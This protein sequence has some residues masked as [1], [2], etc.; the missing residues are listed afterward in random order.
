VVGAEVPGERPCSNTPSLARIRP[1]ASCASALGSGFAGDQRGHHVPAGDPED[2]AGDHRQ[3]DLGV[4]QQ[5][6]PRAASPGGPLMDERAPVAGRGPAAPGCHGGGT[7]L[8]PGACPAR[9]SLASQTPVLHGAS[10]AGPARALPGGRSPASTHTPPPARRTLASSTWTWTPSPPG[11]PPGWRTSPPAPAAT[12]LWWRSSAPPGGAGPAW[13]GAAP[14]RTPAASPCRYPARPPAPPTRS[15]PQVASSTALVPS[16]VDQIPKAGRPREP[17]GTLRGASRV[18]NGN[19]AGPLAA[20]PRI[21]HCYGL[22]NTKHSRRRRATRPRFSRL[23]GVTAGTPTTLLHL[24]ISTLDALHLE[25][26]RLTWHP[27]S[28]SLSRSRGPRS[29]TSLHLGTRR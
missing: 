9:G 7:K 24:A 18:L 6:D 28:A 22:T 2:V 20:A 10:W 29:G 5:P 3:F 21:R 25:A 27:R 12:W 13:S 14:A 19:H 17:A 26:K 15:A 16:G 11:S 23:Q 4:F 1:C 8:G